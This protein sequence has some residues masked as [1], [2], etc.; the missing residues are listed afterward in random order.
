MTILMIEDN[1]ADADLACETLESNQ[2]LLQL[3]VAVDGIEALDFLFQR[4]RYADAVRPDLI[5]LDLNLPRKDGRQVLTEVKQ[6]PELRRIP[7]VV[8][9]SSDAESDIARSYDLGANS[10]VTKPLDLKGFQEIIRAIEQ[11]WLTISKLP[12]PE[13]NGFA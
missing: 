2:L 11:F 7:I 1:P 12:P 13:S 3:F 9:T 5:M 4:G 8:L 6:D 10:Y